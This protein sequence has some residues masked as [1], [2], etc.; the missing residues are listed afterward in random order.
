MTQLLPVLIFML[1]LQLTAFGNIALIDQKGNLPENAD[2]SDVAAV[3]A[4]K[5]AA[6]HAH[7]ASTAAQAIA[8]S[9]QAALMYQLLM[10]KGVMDYF[11]R[12][13]MEKANE[14]LSKK[15]EKLQREL[16]SGKLSSAQYAAIKSAVEE[17]YAKYSKIEL[18]KDKPIQA[19]SVESAKGFRTTNSDLSGGSSFVKTSGDEKS[20]PQ[21]ESMDI[22][23]MGLQNSE[24]R[25]QTPKN[26]SGQDSLKGASENSPGI[27]GGILMPNSGMAMTG[28]VQAPAHQTVSIQNSIQ[29]ETTPNGRGSQTL[30]GRG[31]A[32][33]DGEGKTEF[34]LNP[35]REEIESVPSLEFAKNEQNLDGHY[36]LLS[37]SSPSRAQ[38]GASIKN[39]LKPIKFQK[40]PFSTRLQTEEGLHLG[41]LFLILA[42]AFV[43][44]RRL[45][46]DK[47]VPRVIPEVILK[48]EN[49][50]QLIRISD[51][52]SKR[53]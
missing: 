36:S 7:G 31:L 9:Q 5:S 16:Q 12:K 3:A 13:E 1:V 29:S 11:Q 26:P 18:P 50:F 22:A 48:P 21:L 42:A 14:A 28:G 24:G 20:Q 32:S 52:R 47:K 4:A 53:V 49:D 34:F 35:E 6:V 43:L 33:Q 10:A 37:E 23:R 44:G 45:K 38:W 46:G 15:M 19:D 25:G 17:T 39:L 27:Q 40:T 2:A 51:R 8:A 30:S 41:L